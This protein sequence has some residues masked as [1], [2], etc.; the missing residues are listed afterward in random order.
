ME[1]SKNGRWIIPFKKFSRLRVKRLGTTLLCQTTIP[2]LPILINLK[3]SSANA[4]INLTNLILRKP[5][6]YLFSIFFYTINGINQTDLIY[7][8]YHLFHE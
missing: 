7:Y 6:T 5:V 2:G 1:G 4:T 3:L 8:A